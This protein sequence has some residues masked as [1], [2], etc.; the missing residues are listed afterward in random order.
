VAGGGKLN[1]GRSGIIRNPQSNFQFF[2][3]LS[4]QLGR[5][6]EYNR[7]LHSSTSAIRLSR[8]G[9]ADP[10]GVVPQG[11]KYHLLAF[12]SIFQP[13]YCRRGPK[14]L[15]CSCA[16]GEP[17]IDMQVRNKLTGFPFCQS[18]RGSADVQVQGHYPELPSRDFDLIAL[19]PD[20]VSQL[21]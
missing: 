10:V 13:C 19:V 6:Y 5:C 12:R 7:R 9:D 16:T 21:T 15:G 3:T 4:D 14:R 20:F 2:M 18:E 8:Q 11:L 1:T 17:K